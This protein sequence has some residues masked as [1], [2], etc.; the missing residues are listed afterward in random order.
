MRS[1]YILT[2]ALDF[3]ENNLIEPITLSDIATACNFSLS[4]LHAMFRY[5]FRY[6]L[7]VYLTRRRLSH[8][9]YDLINTNVSIIE[10]ALKYQYNSH[11][12][13]TRAFVKFYGETPSTY[14]KSHR[15][16]QLFPKLELN[17]DGGDKKM[18]KVDIS[19]LYLELRNLSDSYVICTDTVRLM[20]IN[21]KYG[22]SAG[23]IVLAKTA[24]RLEDCTTDNMIVFRIGNDEFAVVTGLYS[25]DEV[26]ELESKIKSL[27]GQVIEAYEHS[28]PLSLRTAI[29]Q[30]P[31][32]LNYNVLFADMHNSI[33]NA[34]NQD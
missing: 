26:K 2:S 3:I 33:E 12:A 11:E 16:T 4:G 7:K 1:F 24:K 14:R 23:D 29:I 6:S 9:A 13:F 10:T 30:I 17:T 21:A 8:A 27:N 18:K 19:D 28:I 32:S 22:L 31:K 5:A 34:K 25:L 20:E 15:Y